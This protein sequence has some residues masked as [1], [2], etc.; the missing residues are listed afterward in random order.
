[1][2]TNATNAPV[3]ALSRK[4]RI[5]LTLFLASM[6]FLNGVVY[7]SA[8]RQVLEGF[9]DYSIFYTA[10][11]MLRRGQGKT[12][13]NNTLQLQ[14]QREFAIAAQTRTGPLPFNHPAFEAALF[15]PLVFLP[16][17]VSYGL[18]IALNAVLLVGILA[19]LRRN[20]SCLHSAP[21]GLFFLAALAFFP[22]AY[23]LMQGQDS[24][25]LLGIFCLAYARLRR[26][27]DLEAGLWLG[28]G[29]FKF[30]LMLP[31]V[32]ILFLRRRWRAVL[33]VTICGVLDALVSWALIGGKEML[34]YPRYAWEVNRH[35]PMHVI[36]PENMA[37]LR[38]LLT[39]WNW[40]R[41]A[42]PWPEIALLAASLGLLIWAARQWDPADRS[43][44][45]SWN[46]GF[47]IAM[48]STFLASYHGY[49]QDMSILFLPLVLLS[50]RVL[51]SRSESWYD[52][53]LRLGL[54]LM[55][56]SPIYIVLTLHYSHQHLFALVLLGLAGVLAAE[57][58]AL[59]LG[60]L[61]EPLPT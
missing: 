36:V 31:F 16:Y 59:K 11:Q 39:G 21:R 32:F 40:A 46:N 27:R 53:A 25:M 19:F 23:A 52:F 5:L 58:A 22:I 42:A 50:C 29:L 47:S 51:Q 34:Y 9:P 35:A 10:G 7:W 45:V 12:L 3:A 14:V 1:M 24:I 54:G 49:N 61:T 28:L 2:A 33:G 20:G 15:V 48:L 13:Y 18:W 4:F 38:G 17:L 43:D 26:G 30:H 8:R 56:F 41:A 44:L 55:F 57:N 6:A 60:T 37:N